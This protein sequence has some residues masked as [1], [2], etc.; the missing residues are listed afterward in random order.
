MQAA[1]F[2]L[3]PLLLA[4]ALVVLAVLMA[5]D[6]RPAS[7]DHARITAWSGT[8][9][10]QSYL[11]GAFLGCSNADSGVEC[12][13]TS[14]F[15]DDDFTH[16]GTTYAVTS[17]A[18]ASGGLG[19]TLSSAIPAA[20]RSSGTL[21]VDNTAL[22]FADASY[23]DNNATVNWSS[24]GISWSAG[25]TVHFSLTIPG[26]PDY[27]VTLSVESMTVNEGEAGAFTV[28]LTD[29]PGADTTITLVKTQYYLS[30]AGDSDARWNV[31]AVSL[32]S[33]TLTFT[34]SNY[35]NGQPVNVTARQDADSCD[36]Q[37]VILILVQKPG[38]G[39][40][41]APISSP[42]GGSGNSVTGVYVTVNDDETGRCGGL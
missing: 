41:A 11:A 30:D 16:G 17:V 37:L 1:F 33:E 35:A 21:Y 7:A 8:L 26:T 5:H 2:R 24:T 39:A 6:S 9:T 36:E 23:G 28:A 13:S 32:A 3:S 38:V 27:G 42:V 22:N 29:D 4:V 40:N 15:T 34:S 12:S 31:N 20:I 14:V 10:V 18:L 19:I 25:D